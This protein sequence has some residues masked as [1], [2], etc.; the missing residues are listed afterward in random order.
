MTFNGEISI[1]TV[2]TVLGLLVAGLW[3]L[4][5]R[6]DGAKREA[7]MKAE[8]AN[9]TAAMARE[10]LA[11][12]KVHVAETFVTKQGMSEQTDRIM[13]AIGDV[14]TRVDSLGSRLD[15]FYENQPA[16]RTRRTGQ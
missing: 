4:W 16:P 1:G 2:L 10:E 14:G 13:K 7:T 15:R 12:Y 3:F 5:S 11:E 9:G 6:I 8:A